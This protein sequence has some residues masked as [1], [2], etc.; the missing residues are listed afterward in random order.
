MDDGGT[1]VTV[2]MI[3]SLTPDDQLNV[4]V[5]RFTVTSAHDLLRL[6]RVFG[7]VTVSDVSRGYFPGISPEP[8]AVGQSAQSAVA[9]FGAT[10][11]GS[12]A[13]T[14]F[15]AVPAGAPPPMPYRAR[16]VYVDFDRPFG[17]L[18]VERRS[19]LI[20]TAGWVADPEPGE[21]VAR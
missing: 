21:P 15:G 3:P 10:G 8:L 14:A 1:R 20:L 5:P 17:F 6:P 16:H 19:G 11:F 9:V 4:T 2:E 13:V 12:A 7:L 18:A